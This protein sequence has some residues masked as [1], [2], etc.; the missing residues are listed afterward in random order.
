[1]TRYFIEDAKCGYDTCFD[2]CGPH[3]TVASA[4]K[5]KTDDGETGWMYCVNP[6]GAWPMIALYGDDVYE[7]IIRGEFPEGPDYEAD[8]FGGL[9]WNPGDEDEGLFELFYKNQNNGAANLIHYA[10]NLCACPKSMEA[11]LLALGKGKYSDEI[12]VPI[13]EVEEFWLEE[14]ED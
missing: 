13:M 10:Y 11:E 9:S 8:S 5:Y 2:G 4:V 3:T 1:M 14:L 12:E 7:E 6:E